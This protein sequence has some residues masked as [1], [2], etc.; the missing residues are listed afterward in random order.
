[1][2][3][4]LQCVGSMP[5]IMIEISPSADPSGTA[6][7][8][9][10]HGPKRRSPQRFDTYQHP[11]YGGIDLHARSMSGCLM[12]R[13]GEL[14]GHRTMQAVP[15]PL[16]KAAAPYRDGRVVAVECLFPWDLAG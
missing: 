2:S 12:N 11:C 3:R 7:M 4:A 1:M 16:L 9:N 6:G 8:G 10:S 15:D 14:L 5:L 13:D